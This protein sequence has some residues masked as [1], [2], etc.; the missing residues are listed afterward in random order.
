MIS[1]PA[2]PGHD[3]CPSGHCL[4]CADDLVGMG[5]PEGQATRRSM[6]DEVLSYGRLSPRA[7]Y[8]STGYAPPR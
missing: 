3:G 2:A 1:E 7:T 4:S 6:N 8:P 5:T